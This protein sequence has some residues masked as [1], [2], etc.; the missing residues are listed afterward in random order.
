[1]ET[2]EEIEYKNCI[3]KIYQDEYYGKS[4]DNWGQDSFLVSYLRDCWIEDK[5]ITK[6]IAIEIVENEKT[7]KE[8][9]KEYFI[10]P[11]EAYI[12]SDVALA[13]GNE[14]NFPDRRWDVSNAGLIFISK[15]DA[16]NIKEAKNVAEGLI[17]TWNDYL[18]GNIYGYTAEDEKNG[19]DISSCWGFYGDYN[20]SG[21]I[22]DAKGSIDWYLENEKIKAVKKKKDLSSLKL[23]ELLSDKNKIIQRH[24]IGIL[25]ELQKDR[26]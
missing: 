21:L 1:M 17:K 25:K 13:I 14:G 16:K 23:G 20:N 19:I 5:E 6:E 7:K 2:L 26:N 10:F 11:L 9:E 15:N 18:S 24:S 22:E 3:I 12:H 4:P 8:Y